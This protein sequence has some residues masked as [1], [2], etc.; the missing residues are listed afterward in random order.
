MKSQIK[1]IPAGIS[2]FDELTGGGFPENF[3]ILLAGTPGTGKS[4][5]SL[6]YI[7]NGA[8]KFNENGAYITLEQTPFYFIEGIIL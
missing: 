1:R 3:V 5:F 8:T 7:Y 2:G 6:E 4:I